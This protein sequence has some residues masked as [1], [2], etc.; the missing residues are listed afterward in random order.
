MSIFV[1]AAVDANDFSG[2][3]RS[4]ILWR[5]ANGGL[6]SWDVDS[7]TF[8]YHPVGLVDNAYSVDAVADFDGNGTVLRKIRH[9]IDHET[10]APRVGRRKLAR[11][12]DPRGR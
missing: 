4:D 10:E 9:I 3:G 8:H 6:A 12:L 11:L 7:G 5:H 2:D 1:H